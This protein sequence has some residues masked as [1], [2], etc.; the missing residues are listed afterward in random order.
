MKDINVCLWDDDKFKKNQ[1]QWT[2][3][4]ERSSSD[5][6]FMSWEWLST[7]WDIFAE[8]NMSLRLF[9]AQDS[10]GKL[11]GI[12]PFYLST[13]ITKKIHR[14]K[15]LQ[16]IG[17]CWRGQPTMRTELL[18]FIVDNACS[19]EVIGALYEYIDS[20]AE[21]DELVL[22]DMNKKSETFQI[23][24]EQKLI[25]NSYYRSAE[26]FESYHLNILGNFTDFCS[27]LGKNTRLKLVN[28]RKLLET[29]GKVEFHEVT[30]G[31]LSSSFDLLNSLHKQRWGNPVFEGKRLQFNRTVAQLMALKKGLLFSILT[32]DGKPVSIQFN[33]ILDKHEY[34][35][36]AGFDEDFHKK[37]SLG[38]L[39]F[40]YEIESAFKKKL[41]VYDFLAGEGKN[42]QYKARLTSCTTKIVCMQII[43]SNV[44]KILYRLYDYYSGFR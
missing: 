35:I 32:L 29:L 34:N 15:R 24:S 43:R 14:T 3:L 2:N 22:S 30:D 21:W 1:E 26:E 39:H 37:I 18:D 25:K 23:L 41:K 11:M 28:R 36:Q 27:L 5:K 9:V 8:P 40:G 7:W 10:F 20:S 13:V 38:Y 6:L 44:L 19:R 12:A 42:T 16:F 17:N 33:Y 4:L 31:D